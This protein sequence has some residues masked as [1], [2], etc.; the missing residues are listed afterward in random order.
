MGVL[1]CGAEELGAGAAAR[2]R[3]DE[4]G[5]AE[6]EAGPLRPAAGRLSALVSPGNFD[7][8]TA[9]RVRPSGFPRH[10]RGFLR[11]ASG[12]LRPLSEVFASGWGA[13]LWFQA[14]NSASE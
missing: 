4:A 10:T 7:R 12:F 13:T 6:V 5:A 8:L 14:G 1:R 3:D 2:K 9:N 11:P